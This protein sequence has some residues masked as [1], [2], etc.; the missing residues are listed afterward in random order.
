[1]KLL[2]L[3]LHIYVILLPTR[4]LYPSGQVVLIMYPDTLDSRYIAVQY[5]IFITVWS[6][7]WWNLGMI[8]NSLK[9]PHTST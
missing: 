6:P 9:T 4:A 8:V 7:V 5:Y 1:M 2:F 3:N